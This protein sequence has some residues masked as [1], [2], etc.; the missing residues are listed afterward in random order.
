MSTTAVAPSAM[1]RSTRR[2]S[3]V[4]S[5]TRLLRDRRVL[6]VTGPPIVADSRAD[7]RFH[8]ES[9]THAIVAP[10]SEPTKEPSAATPVRVSRPN[11]LPVVHLSRL[12]SVYTQAWPLRF[13]RAPV[14]LLIATIAP[15]RRAGSSSSPLTIDPSFASRP[16]PVIGHSG[17]GAS[18]DRARTL[19]ARPAGRRATQ[20]SS[21]SG[22]AV[23]SRTVASYYAWS[24]CTRRAIFQTDMV[25]HGDTGPDPER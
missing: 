8:A 9:S 23:V 10:P 4:G 7:P 19:T 13:L 14:V 24:F 16:L 22:L 25:R 11:R 15:N 17:C 3:S 5:S 20:P 2:D 18:H 21:R 1:A 12:N 6:C